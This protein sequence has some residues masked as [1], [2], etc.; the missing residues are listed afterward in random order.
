MRQIALSSLQIRAIEADPRFDGGDFY[1][2]DV[3]EGPWRGMCL[4][5]G[6]GQVSYRTE[7]EF[8]ERFP[9][10]PQAGRRK[11]QERQGGPGCL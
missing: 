9:N 4:A 10:M 5:R 3:G 7:E 6:I 11:S 2:A 8:D 1:G